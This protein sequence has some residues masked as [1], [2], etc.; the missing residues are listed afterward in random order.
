MTS[1]FRNSHRESCIAICSLQVAEWT[2][3]GGFQAIAA[4][5]VRLRPHTEIEKNKTYI[6][7]TI[8]VSRDFNRI[9][10]FIVKIRNIVDVVIFVAQ[11]EP[12]IMKK[13]SETGEILV[14]NDSYEGYCK[15]LADLIA[16]KLGISCKFTVKDKKKRERR[17]EANDSRGESSFV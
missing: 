3:E 12:Y 5:Y 1:V 17:R 10:A 15:D 2:D 8:M 7:T 6:V 14:G 9:N 13:M 16:K 4:K 11:E